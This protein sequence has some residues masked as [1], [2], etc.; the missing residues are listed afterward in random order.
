MS[1]GIYK[2]ENL[3][4]GKIYIGQSMHIETRWS[5]HC[6]TSNQNKSLISKAISEYGK[7]NFSFQILEECLP[8]KLTE[9]ETEYIFKYNSFEPAGYN[10]AIPYGD[11]QGAFSKY[12]YSQ[13]LNIIEDI[14]NSTLTFKEIANKYNLDLSMIY[15]LNRGDYH[16]LPE[17]TYPLREVKDLSKKYWYCIDCGIQIT[18]GAKRC[19]TCDHKNQQVAKRPSRIE[20]KRLIYTTPFTT[21]GTQFGV[22][23]NTIKKWCQAYDLPYRKKDIKNFNQEEWDK[24]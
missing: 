22:S 3:L 20:L 16:S 14:K 24:I 10:V 21:I 9:L 23:D 18:K 8:E 15:Y 19:T 5:E 11:G 7:E 6:R 4:N 2:I 12:T 17:E 1:I 13:L